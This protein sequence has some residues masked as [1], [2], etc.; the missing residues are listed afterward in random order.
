VV[1]ADVVTV[2]TVA[3]VVVKSVVVVRIVDDKIGLLTIQLH[4][5]DTTES[6]NC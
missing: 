3:V 1:V 5:A 2:V 6:G 4:A